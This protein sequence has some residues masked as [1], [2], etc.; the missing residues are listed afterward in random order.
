MDTSHYHRSDNGLPLILAGR[1]GGQLNPGRHIRF[2]AGTTGTHLDTLARQPLWQAGLDYDHG[3]G[4][5]VG[6]YLG[7]H[8]GPQRIAKGWNATPLA[9]TNASRGWPKNSRHTVRTWRGMR[10]RIQRALVMMPLSRSLGD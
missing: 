1:L 2:P 3:T 6:A 4:H 8:E 7:V 5:G 9:W 10:C